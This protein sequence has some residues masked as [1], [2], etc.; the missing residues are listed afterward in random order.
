MSRVYLV[1]HGEANARWSESA[2]PGLSELGKSQA[3]Q[4]AIELRQRIADAQP[5]LIS[6]PLARAQ[7]TAEPL[8]DLLQLEFVID[9]RIREIPSP[10]PLSERQDW[11]RAFMTQCWPE[12][13]QELHDWRDQILEA[14]REQ[15]TDAVLFT[16]FLV[17]NAV[18]GACKARKETLVVW[19]A[20]A[21]ITELEVVDN[22][23]S[24]R[25]LGE[26]MRSRVN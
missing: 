13:P 7:Q 9:D 14:V 12:Q 21:S 8:A 11:L 22:Q 26:Q 5:R 16:H 23:I 1:R 17:I 2:D 24:V 10:V 19:P 25:Q 6:S 18:V 15:T 4:A 20:N 3:D